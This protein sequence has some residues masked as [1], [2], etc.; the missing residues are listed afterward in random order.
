MKKNAYI[1]NMCG[2][3]IQTV[4][5]DEGVTPFMIRCAASAGCHGV[6]QSCFYRVP[7]NIVAQWEFFRPTT[8]QEIEEQVQIHLKSWKDAGES[9]EQHARETVKQH[10][11]DGGLFLRRARRPR[12]ESEKS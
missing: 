8:E 12:T 1:C 9:T 10:I 6:M 3:Q 11:E 2:G 4:D 5:R 7:P